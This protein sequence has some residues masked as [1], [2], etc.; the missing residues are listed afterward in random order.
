MPD[1]TREISPIDIA[2]AVDEDEESTKNLP[3]MEGT[4]QDRE[5]MTRMGKIQE[6]RVI[7]YA[8]WCD[9]KIMS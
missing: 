9:M 7:P 1:P 5:D 3:K 8:L 4:P 6:L 2:N